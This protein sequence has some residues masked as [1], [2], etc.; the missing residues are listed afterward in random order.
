[1]PIVISF[2]Y[3][4]VHGIHSECLVNETETLYYTNKVSELSRILL[5]ANP[6]SIN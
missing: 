6:I 5:C 1:M 3:N 2:D 4:N